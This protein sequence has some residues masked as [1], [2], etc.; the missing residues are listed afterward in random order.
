MT[1]PVDF[2]IISG[3]L[4]PD[5]MRSD[6]IIRSI[7]PHKI[8]HIARK[9][10]YSS[11]VVTRTKYMTVDMLMEICEPLVDKGTVIGI[12]TTF[13][14][15][16]FDVSGKTKNSNQSHPYVDMIVDL[17][18]HFK[19]KFNNQV[20]VGGPNANWYK[21]IFHADHV[22]RGYAETE[23]PRLLN[24]IKNG[25]L[26]KKTE[27][28]WTIQ[29][30]DFRWHH[31]D[32]V[33]PGETLPLELSRGCIFKC[34]FCTYEMIGKK[35]GTYERDMILIREELIY[36]Y[37]EFGVKSYC[38]TSDTFNDS[39]ERMNDWCDML[40]T[41]PFDITYTGY[42]RLD[43]MSAFEKTTRRLYDTGLIGCNFGIESFH[44]E[45]SKAI[46]KGFNGK[47]GKETLQH[48]YENVFDRNI[49][50]FGTMIIGLPHEPL[51]SVYESAE[52]SRNNVWFGMKWNPLFL[53]N[54][55]S[56]GEAEIEN[57]GHISN[58]EFSR[59]AINHG[60]TFPDD[61]DQQNWKSDITD[62]KEARRISIE[63]NNARI[64]KGPLVT[65]WSAI[66][67]IG[68]FGVEPKDLLKTNII[69]NP[70]YKNELLNILNVKYQA[71][72]LE[73]ISKS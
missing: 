35:K 44:P 38:L 36:N 28:P 54:N 24:N 9:F 14:L 32:C 33:M 66:N 62:F 37:N 61:N 64:Q 73:Y 30:C 29:T 18:K 25:G 42:A 53:V 4:T 59:N 40:E 10:G 11:I 56:I 7:G 71:K 19:K 60:Y 39:D 48:L 27:S 3:N 65:N 2:L 15:T 21:E 13:I 1:K 41:L 31:S 22:I 26:Y 50:L 57:V 58:S 52:W 47:R 8:S 49:N 43:L 23:I 67:Y 51:E 16:W 69:H 68:M 17:I 70:T 12:S 45:A 55:S 46:G 72:L 34:D 6:D 63:L 5:G 20:V